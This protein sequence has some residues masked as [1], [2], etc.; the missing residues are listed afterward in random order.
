VDIAIVAG[1]GPMGT[2]LA[3]RFANAGHRVVIGSRSAQRAASC[4]ERIRERVG[5]SADAQGMTNADAAGSCEL[6]FVTVP[7]A[8]HAEL[9]GSLEGH[10]RPDTVVVDTTSPLAS[11]LG[12]PAWQ[13]VQPWAGSA[14]EQAATL[15]PEDV[16]LVAGFHSVAASLLRDVEN[17]IHADVL[18]SGDDDEAKAIVGGLVEEI[19]QLRWADAGELSTARITESL[20]ALLISV[21]RKYGVRSA[22]V[23]LTG[24]DRWGSPG[25]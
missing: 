16:R 1:T 12:G 6:L 9:Y 18:L 17:D 13:V 21:N 22:G 14:A 5:S 24:R 23:R 4:A 7:F 20:T 11:A 3:L 19:P 8:G 25:G 2:G 10:L 15:L